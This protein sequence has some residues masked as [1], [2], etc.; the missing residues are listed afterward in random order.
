MK[1]FKFYSK[2]IWTNEIRITAEVTK[3]I[4]IVH[5]LSIEVIPC[6]IT[7]TDI[8]PTSLPCCQQLENW[9]LLYIVSW[10]KCHHTYKFLNPTFSVH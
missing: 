2:N 10:G 3:S 4:K 5:V 9:H 1:P 7:L 6:S 8:V